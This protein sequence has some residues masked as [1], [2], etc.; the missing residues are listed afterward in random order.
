MRILLL[1]GNGHVGH[2][3]LR[4]LAPLGEVVASTR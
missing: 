1:G 4:S 2:E 3:L